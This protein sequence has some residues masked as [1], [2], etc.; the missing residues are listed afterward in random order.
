M[1]AEMICGPERFRELCATN[2][3]RVHR[4]LGRVSGQQNATVAPGRARTGMAW[5][6]G[7]DVIADYEEISKRTLSVRDYLASFRKPPAFANFALGDHRTAGG[8]LKSLCARAIP[9]LAPRHF[10]QQTEHREHERLAF[11]I[12]GLDVARGSVDLLPHLG[13]A[14]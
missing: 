1:N 9:T 5:M 6:T 7:R 10:R 2:H 12:I 13:G 11:E 14:G 3:D 8:G 4:L